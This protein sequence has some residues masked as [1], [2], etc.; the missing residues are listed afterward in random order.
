MR[1]Y[2]EKLGEHCPICWSG[3]EK[4]GRREDKYIYRCPHCG[5]VTD[6]RKANGSDVQLHPNKHKM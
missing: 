2:R 5:M 4:V 6:G 3:M 1:I